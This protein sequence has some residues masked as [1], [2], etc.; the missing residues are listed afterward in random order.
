MWSGIM[1]LK[2]L[3]LLSILV[4][5]A[6][7]SHAEVKFNGFASIVTGIDLEDEGEESTVDEGDA[8][9]SY[10][11]RT[12]DNLQESKVA[13][14]WAADLGEGMRFV[15]QTMARGNSATGFQLNYDW[16]YFDFNIGDSAKL[17]VGRLRAPFYKYSDYLDVGYAYHW[18]TPPESMYSLTF[19]NIDGV[20]YQQNMEAM[21][22]DHSLTVAIGT[23]QGILELGTEKVQ[24]S[25]ENFI[26]INWSATIGNHEFSAA[27]AQADV[28]V[29]ADATAGLAAVAALGGD[30]PNQVLINGDLG[31]F[32]GVGYTGTFGDIVIYSE[33][34]IVKV[35]DSIF[36]DTEGGYLGT[37]YNMDDYTYHITYGI[38]KAEEKEYAAGTNG[39]DLGI[40]GGST[41]NGTTLN[42]TARFL[43][44][45]ESST[46]TIGVRKD[47][48][49]SS[50]IK[51]DLDILTED[52]IQT[53][54][55]AAT[56]E[57]RTATTLKFA[58]ETMF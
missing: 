26:A 27:Y 56:S 46:V 34:S 45:G 53:S 4:L 22:L 36:A 29:P 54:Q 35:D 32:I 6:S 24:S 17:K 40:A 51:V 12:T 58:I 21:G 33:Y 9:S 5:I 57:E 43:G 3:L 2:T 52:R 38:R 49:I 25:L 18:I 13:L 42:S 8:P 14:Q 47:I 10:N 7:V 19:S 11:T 16:A 44:N 37:S 50:A 15:G 20:S 41:A 55:I 28:Y 48:G 23:Y 39:I 1:R 31:S 30:D